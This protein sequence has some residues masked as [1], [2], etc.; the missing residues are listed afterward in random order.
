MKSALKYIA[1]LCEYIAALTLITAFQLLGR[2]GLPRVQLRTCVAEDPFEKTVLDHVGKS[3]QTTAKLLEDVSRLDT[4]AKTAL[5]ELTKVKNA[6]NDIAGMQ[7]ALKKLDVA[8]KAQRRAEFGCP[9]QRITRDEELR[10]RFNLL[11]RQAVNGEDNRLKKSIDLLKKA[12]GEDTSPGST[13]IATD[14][15]LNEIYDTLAT[16]GKWNTLGV[17]R[18]GSKTLRLPIKT[19]R[20]VANFILTEAGTVADDT[21]KAGSTVSMDMEIIAVLLN[22]SLQLLEDDENDVTADIMSDFVEAYNE[23]LDFAAFNGTGAA[24]ATSGGYT[25]AFQFG[26]LATAATGRTTVANLTLVDFV[27]CLT[28]VD[29]VVLARPSKWWIHPT[30]LARVGGIVDANGRPLFQTALEA[31]APGS[32]GS[33][34]GY[35]VELT[36]AAPSADGASSRIA[37][38]GD[39]ASM[40]VGVRKDYMFEASDQ[41]RWNTL[42]RSFRA[43]GR[44]GV[45]GRRALGLAVLQTSAT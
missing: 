33:I 39:P 10:T 35:P 1:G 8:L 17:R 43:W 32:I 21:T 20:P 15:L 37:L 14:V 3:Q 11:V 5:E 31:P 42:E 40:V 30:Q 44:A 23:R 19:A 16:F 13:Y 45:R 34:M 36:L 29:P 27:R 28:T 24:N 4:Q 22:V 41:H 26:T 7:I 6:A 18:V 9:F 2:A 25:G 12:L 38:F